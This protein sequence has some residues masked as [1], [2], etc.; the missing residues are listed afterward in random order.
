[1]DRPGKIKIGDAK[2]YFVG[3][4]DDQYIIEVRN[5]MISL[6]PKGSRKPDAEVHVTPAQLYRHLMLARASEEARAKQKTTRRKK[7]RRGV[8]AFD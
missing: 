5:L 4:D 2:K 8:L 7:V 1:M 3:V 6:R